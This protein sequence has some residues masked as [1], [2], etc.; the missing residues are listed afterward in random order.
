MKHD[1]DKDKFKIFKR[2]FLNLNVS[3]ILQRYGQISLDLS[4]YYVYQ[5]IKIGK[6]NLCHNN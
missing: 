3:H 5:Y 2:A 6:D 1:R 4:C